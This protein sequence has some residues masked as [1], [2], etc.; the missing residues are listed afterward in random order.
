M[1][2]MKKKTEKCGK[3]FRMSKARLKTSK[4]NKLPIINIEC[5]SSPIIF[6]T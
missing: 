6:H 4:S 5:A 3:K 1:N 2:F